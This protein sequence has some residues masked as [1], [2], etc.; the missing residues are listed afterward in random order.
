MQGSTRH[1]RDDG[2]PAFWPLLPA[3]DRGGTGAERYGDRRPAE[4]AAVA[5]APLAAA[6]Q[7]N[8]IKASGA[9]QTETRPTPPAGS[10][11]LRTQAAPGS[12]GLPQA[13]ALA[14]LL[15]LSRLMRRRM[16]TRSWR[17]ADPAVPA[18]RPGPWQ[19]LSASGKRTIG[20]CVAPA[21]MGRLVVP[22]ANGPDEA[23]AVGAMPLAA[24]GPLPPSRALVQR[25]QARPL[26]VA[27]LVAACR[28]ARSRP[29]GRDHD[30]SSAFS[31]VGAAEPTAGRAL[32][33]PGPISGDP[34]P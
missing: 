22:S 30:D 34:A 9:R 21:F 10:R 2:V 18:K 28:A 14:H 24:A 13:A 31:S 29:T 12:V 32:P 15:A 20:Q 23:L 17:P 33:W 5:P 4:P 6:D 27:R 3:E 11:R 19:A 1:V 8:G 16:R 25:P 26:G 7:P